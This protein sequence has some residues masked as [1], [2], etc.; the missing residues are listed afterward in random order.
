MK[1]LSTS[2]PS[3]RLLPD[4]EEFEDGTSIVTFYEKECYMTS[5]NGKICS[6][7]LVPGQV[8][9][10]SVEDS[11][12]FGGLKTPDGFFVIVGV[13]PEEKQ[14]SKE[15]YETYEALRELTPA[16]FGAIS[17]KEGCELSRA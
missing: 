17:P 2:L 5:Y 9:W 10:S 11:G 15:T 4:F 8:E 6:I 1:I 13:F 16:L 12:L 14:Y 3:L 7:Q